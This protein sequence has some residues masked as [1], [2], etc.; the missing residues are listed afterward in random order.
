MVLIIF[1]L[2]L[3]LG[4]F[5]CFKGKLFVWFKGGV[6]V[7]FL[8]FWLN[9]ELWFLM[10]FFEIVFIVWV[11]I[12]GGGMLMKL[13]LDIIVGGICGVLLVLSCLVFSEDLGLE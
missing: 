8:G 4:F 5:L 9:F 13:E 11:L 1:K 2:D 6:M 10:L 12:M 7:M 3:E